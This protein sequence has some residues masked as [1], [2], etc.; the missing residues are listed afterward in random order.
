MRAKITKADGYLC[1]PEGHTEV[2]FPFGETVFGQVA[3]W[4]IADR[5]ASRTFDPVS[6]RKVTAPPETKR[7]AAPRKPRKPKP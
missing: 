7:K 3:A 2:H 6:E 1:C 5:A 4:A